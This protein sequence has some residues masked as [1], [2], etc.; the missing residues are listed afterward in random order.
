MTSPTTA[1]AHLII[2]KYLFLRPRR[3]PSISLWKI[4]IYAR[5]PNV[6]TL[7]T[8]AENSILKLHKKPFRLGFLLSL[9]LFFFLSLS[10]FSSGRLFSVYL[11]KPS[12]YFC[13][14]IYRVGCCCFSSLLLKLI[15]K[16]MSTFFGQHLLSY[17]CRLQPN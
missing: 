10:V 12:N 3:V 15:R 11:L 14:F 1:R 16:T 13:L 17:M 5:E 6:I 4:E 2:L 7:N 8:E 9:S